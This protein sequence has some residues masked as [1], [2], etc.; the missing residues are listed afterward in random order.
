MYYLADELGADNIRCNMV[1]PSWMWGPPVQ[2]YVEGTAKQKGIPVEEALNDIVGDFPLAAHDR[3]RRGRRRGDVLR[4]RPRQGRHR[5]AP[6]GEL[7]RDDALTD[8]AKRVVVWGT[9]FVGQAGDPRDRAATPPSS[10][11]ASASATRTRSARTPASSAASTRSASTAT[12]DLDA[13]VA[14]E[15]DALVHYGPT[16]AHPKDNIRDIGA[17]LRAGI[18]VCSTA[19]TPWVWPAMSLN[20]PDWI[21][22]DHRGVRGRRLVVLHDR[23]RSRA[24]PT[25]C[26]P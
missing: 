26:S 5:P 15:P 11:S 10:S 18:D 22:P 19:M 13:L 20:P 1:V 23:H 17:F 4:L 21:A 7:R 16:A 25:T 2:M 3:G 24:S 6:D 12:D 14:L 8:A 9:G